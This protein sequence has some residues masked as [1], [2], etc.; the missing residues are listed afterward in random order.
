MIS[1]PLISFNKKFSFLY[2]NYFKAF[3][4]NTK[5]TINRF[6]FTQIYL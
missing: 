3:K 6:L 4:L 1:I 5:M 2:E